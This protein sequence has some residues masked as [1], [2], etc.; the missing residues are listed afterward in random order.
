MKRNKLFIIV[1]TIVCLCFGM[2]S[3]T[4]FADGG[5]ETRPLFNY[6]QPSGYTSYDKDTGIYSVSGQLTR[7]SAVDAE[8]N[9]LNPV[10][11]DDTIRF[12]YRFTETRVTPAQGSDWGM[13]F[14]FRN[15]D[16][17]SP[18]WSTSYAAYVLIFRDQMDLRVVYNS[19][20]GSPV[21]NKSVS[22]PNILDAECNII[23]NE[24]HTIEINIDDENGII[25]VYRDKGEEGEVSITA[26]CKMADRNNN[27]AFLDRGGY[28]FSVNQFSIDV[29]D[30]YFHNTKNTEI[31]DEVQRY[32]NII[33][34]PA[35]GDDNPGDNPGGNE[36]ENENNNNNN[37]NNNT[38][39]KGCGKG[40][41]ALMP[42]MLGIAFVC[43]KFGR[44]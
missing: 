19:E 15:L 44:K 37:N 8:N 26:D 43:T 29:K 38:E 13:Y 14:T 3:T 28:S 31:D 23:D 2:M 10:Y 7:L 11:S 6:F 4:A 21:V 36:N 12:S 41:I 16:G 30:L 25:T 34:P 42:I 33:N 1:M 17:E 27:I 39:E 32:E 22:I 20:V 24:F 35:P 5:A 40:G 9:L 18:L